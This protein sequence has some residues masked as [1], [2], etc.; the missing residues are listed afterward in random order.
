MGVGGVAYG[1]VGSSS[2]WSP[3]ATGRRVNV[4]VWLAAVGVGG[5]FLGS[6][7][8]P[9]AT[10][11][12]TEPAAATAPPAAGGHSLTDT[13]SMVIGAVMFLVTTGLA[14]AT[15][16]FRSKLRGLFASGEVVYHNYVETRSVDPRP[17]INRN[18][19]KVRSRL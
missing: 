14:V 9:V 3:V 10:R 19:P 6:T 2:T 18:V 13:R 4:A 5:I 12:D 8:F 15:L 16:V 1:A 17:Y 7:A 11:H